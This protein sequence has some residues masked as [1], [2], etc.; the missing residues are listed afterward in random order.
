MVVAGLLL[1][2]Q[3]EGGSIQFLVLLSLMPAC[4]SE[5]GYLGNLS[6][7]AFLT[8]AAEFLCQFTYF[9]APSSSRNE[10]A[11]VASSVNWT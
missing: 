11:L 10:E 7:D 3:T 1:F 4:S 8:L 9:T 2:C 5:A 6:K